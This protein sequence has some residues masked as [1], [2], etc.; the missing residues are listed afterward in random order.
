MICINYL[1]RNLKSSCQVELY[2]TEVKKIGGGGVRGGDGGGLEG[3]PSRAHTCHQVTGWLKL[4]VLA[5][6]PDKPA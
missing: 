1:L 5:A 3:Y 2:E 6:K 4:Q